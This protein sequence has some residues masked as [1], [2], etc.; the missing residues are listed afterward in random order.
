MVFYVGKN[1]SS[2]Y[3]KA[4]VLSAA[5][6]RKAIATKV[7]AIRPFSE[8]QLEAAHINLHLGAF[9][10]TGEEVSVILPSKGFILART[11][12]RITLAPHICGMI[13]GRS[14]LAQRG[15]SIE[16]SSTFIEPG[17]DCTMVLEIFNAS[18]ESIELHQGDK[19]AKLVLLRMTDEI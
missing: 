16:Q 13:E 18:D 14:K 2:D 17:S 6:I 10:L 4:M 15:I 19:I 12:E 7:V 1:N 11:R 3:S 5:A 9:L 8:D